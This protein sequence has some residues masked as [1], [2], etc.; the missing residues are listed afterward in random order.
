MPNECRCTLEITGDP[1][2]VRG[3]LAAIA[4]PDSESEDQR[5][6]DFER[7]IPL[8]P[9]P[10]E[11]L[12]LSRTEPIDWRRLRIDSWGTKWNAVS[13]TIERQPDDSGAV[14]KFD[15]AWDPPWPILRTLA[16]RFPRLEFDFVYNDIQLPM[17]GRARRVP[18]QGWVTIDAR[19]DDGF[20]QAAVEAKSGRW[21][22]S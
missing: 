17:A 11:K 18:G 15:T 19:Y 6:F 7:V 21:G 9:D 1:N 5:L 12:G 8:P 20:C 14:I 10:R 2:N 4:T 13:V 3:C 22:A 16:D